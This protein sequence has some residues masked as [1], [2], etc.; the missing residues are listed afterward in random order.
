MSDDDRYDED[1]GEEW[2]RP[3][4]EPDKGKPEAPRDPGIEKILQEAAIT[5]LF[6]VAGFDALTAD[7]PP[8]VILAA[9]KK[10]GAFLAGAD[11]LFREAC[12][13]EGVRRLREVKMDAET[14]RRYVRVAVSVEGPA[15]E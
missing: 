3:K 9:M 7:S 12:K 15:V 2:K 8:E 13:A 1:A 4:R 14:A 6:T 11:K 10:L 5:D